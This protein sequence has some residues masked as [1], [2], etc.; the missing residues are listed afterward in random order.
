VLPLTFSKQ[1]V[2]SGFLNAAKLSSH[3]SGR[4]LTDHRILF[5]GSGSAGVGV[6]KQVM[7]F[8][9]LQG[10]S[11][12]DAKNRIYFIDS[13]GLI[14]IDRPGKLAEHKKCMFRLIQPPLYLIFSGSLCA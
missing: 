14:T 5:L 12:E 6:A 7:S 2:L 10:L 13:Q 11:E 8:F 9:T 3:A 4:D 1:V